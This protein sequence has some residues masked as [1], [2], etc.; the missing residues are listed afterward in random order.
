VDQ[1]GV[2]VGAS[3]GLPVAVAAVGAAAVELCLWSHASTESNGTSVGLGESHGRI[4]ATT[5]GNISVLRKSDT[6]MRQV[7]GISAVSPLPRRGSVPK[8]DTPRRLGVSAGRF[9]GSVGGG[10]FEPPTSGM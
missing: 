1:G 2:G 10:G 6:R 7:L 4:L 8:R 9:R 5:I 3:A